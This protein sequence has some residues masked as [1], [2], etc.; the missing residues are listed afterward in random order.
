MLTAGTSL[1]FIL[2]FV[3]LCLLSPTFKKEAKETVTG[4]G[5]TW[6]KVLKR[7]PTTEKLFNEFSQLVDKHGVQSTQVTEFLDKHS[8]NRLFVQLATKA[9]QLNEAV[10]AR[11]GGFEGEK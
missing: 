11:K 1:G 6:M 7:P 8:N 10:N 3:L 5:D 9:E 2:F 4:W